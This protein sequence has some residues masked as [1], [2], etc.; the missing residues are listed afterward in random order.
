MKYYRIDLSDGCNIEWWIPFLPENNKSWIKIYANSILKNIK[1]FNAYLNVQ[2]KEKQN[3]NEWI[4]SI[5][6]PRQGQFIFYFLLRSV[7]I[8]YRIHL[9]IYLC[10]YFE[11][12]ILTTTWVFL[13]YILTYVIITMVL[14]ALVKEKNI[15]NFFKCQN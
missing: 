14:W 2:H 10:L 9:L 7:F 13:G 1:L 3:R 11:E 12:V 8:K 5:F 15:I 4:K 6:G